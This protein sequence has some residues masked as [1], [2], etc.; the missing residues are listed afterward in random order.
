MNVRKDLYAYIPTDVEGDEISIKN[1]NLEQNYPNPFNPSTRI[2]YSVSS[3][4]N[5]TI[6]V[7]DLI[8]LQR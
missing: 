6:K 4:Q 5:V 2:Q 7:Y 8:R 1:F 3:T